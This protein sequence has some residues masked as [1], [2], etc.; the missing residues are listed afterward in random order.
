MKIKE[1]VK[2]IKK[3][4]DKHFNKINEYMKQEGGEGLQH[5]LICITSLN[6]ITFCE[7]SLL[8]PERRVPLCRSFV[9][10][11]ERT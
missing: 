5:F 10:I 1:K 9:D 2:L 7:A 8:L 3:F 11:M 4:T 6:N